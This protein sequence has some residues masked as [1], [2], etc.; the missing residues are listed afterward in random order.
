MGIQSAYVGPRSKRLAGVVTRAVV[1]I[2]NVRLWGPLFMLGM[3]LL[4]NEQVAPAG[5]PDAQES[6]TEPG[7]PAPV[8]VTSALN[9]AAPPAITVAADG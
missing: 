8:G 1:V 3:G 5:N 6:E 2:S 4:V 9:V 7:N